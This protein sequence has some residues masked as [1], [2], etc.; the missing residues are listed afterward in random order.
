M[1]D[2]TTAPARPGIRD[3][4][5]RD[6]LLACLLSHYRQHGYVLDAATT[7]PGLLRLRSDADTVIVRS[8]PPASPTQPVAPET[9]AELLQRVEAEP[10]RATG[11]L[12]SLGGFDEDALLLAA[13][14][15]QLQ[16]LDRAALVSLLGPVPELNATVLPP[17]LPPLQANDLP[18]T[19]V[20]RQ[21][22]FSSAGWKR[23]R[24][25]LAIVLP[26]LVLLA[27]GYP[28]WVASKVRQAHSQ[29]QAD[30]Q[31]P[32]FVEPP[33]KAT[34]AAAQAKSGK[35]E[36]LTGVWIPRPL[37]P[38][39]APSSQPR[40]AA[41]PQPPPDFVELSRSNVWTEQELA[42]WERRQQESIRALDSGATKTR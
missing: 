39:P 7:V 1:Q 37:Q 36:R 13:R 25:A 42:E 18:E 22:L 27:W 32:R 30:A 2:D 4:I 12:A 24:P 33:A 31:R 17:P 3:A 6:P 15:P 38:Q 5:Q 40:P 11:L 34:P 14:H 19:P 9:V 21:T 35:P 16:L 28:T 41:T 26:L 29:A 10:G 23:S 8:A 20:S